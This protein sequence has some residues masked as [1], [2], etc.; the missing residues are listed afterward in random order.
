MQNHLKT[1][2]MDS[3]VKVQN[4]FENEKEQKKGLMLFGPNGTGK[5]TAI[6]PYSETM[7]AMTSIALAME[8]QQKGRSYLGRFSDHD[9]VIDDLGRED[10]IVKSYG[11][12]VN[13]M[14]DLIFIRYQA[15]Q[16]GKKTHFTTNLTF[17]ELQ[18]RYGVAIADRILEMCEPVEFLGESLRK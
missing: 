15:F 10:V 4:Y 11:D 1:K 13:M 3:L 5:T 16:R 8:V 18:E 9:M 2:T 12:E 6:R 7:W 17:S 14:H